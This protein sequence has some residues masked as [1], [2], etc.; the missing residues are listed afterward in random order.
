MADPITVRWFTPRNALIRRVA[1]LERAWPAEKNK[2]ADLLARAILRLEPREREV[3]LGF[4]LAR[5]AAG[6]PPQEPP[7]GG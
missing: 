1:A 5:L 4:A 6:R 7:V 3:A 2:K